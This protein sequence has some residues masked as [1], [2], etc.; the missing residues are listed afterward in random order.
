MEENITF[1]GKEAEKLFSVG[2]LSTVVK[3]LEGC[4]PE[5]NCMLHNCSNTAL[6]EQFGHV[7][8]GD[9]EGSY[10]GLPVRKRKFVPLGEIWLMD[11]D[12]QIIR[13]FSLPLT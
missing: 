9:S 1:S 3:M 2:E 6:L 8:I 7:D 5:V 10:Y 4:L 12:A 13:K 11:K